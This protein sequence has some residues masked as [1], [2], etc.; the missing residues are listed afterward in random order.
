MQKTKK[1][2]PTTQKNKT[3]K[4]Q[5]NGRD[6]KPKIQNMK[7]TQSICIKTKSNNPFQSPRSKIHVR[8]KDQQHRDLPQKNKIQK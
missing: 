3:K 2:D 7:Y 1:E 5:S 4:T 6:P 8:I